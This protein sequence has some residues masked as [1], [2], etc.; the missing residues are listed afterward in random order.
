MDIIERSKDIWNHKWGRR[1]IIAAAIVAVLSIP[2]RCH[3]PYRGRVIDSVNGQP[4]AGAVAVA[5]WSTTSIN[6]AGGTTRCLDAE[7]AVTDEN[8]EFQIKGSRGR[9]LGLFAGTMD[10]N[11][12][13]VGYEKVSCDWNYIKEPGACFEKPGEF[14]GDRAIF[15]L[16]SVAIDRLGYEGRPPSGGCGRK[17]GRPLSAYT[18]EVKRW[19]DVMGF[20]K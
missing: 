4:I 14:D 12:Y 15:P 9:L 19:E 10:I 18:K 16:K 20:D 17:D 1:I 3:G 7:E 5:S 8:G 2:M 13:K 6:V 11:I